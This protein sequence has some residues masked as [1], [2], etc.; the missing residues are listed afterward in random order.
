MRI[1]VDTNILLRSAQPNHPLCYKATRAV[2]KLLR[3]NAAVFFCPQNIAELCNVA[4]RPTAMNGLGFSLSEA[5][6]EIA[7]IEDL[8]TLLPD[9][10]AIYPGKQLVRGHSVRGATIYDAR[11]VAVMSV[12]EVDSIFTFN[13]V[14]FQRYGN[15]KRPPTGRGARLRRGGNL[16]WP[17]RPLGAAS[18]GPVAV[19]IPTSP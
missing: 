4:T 16:R 10:P 9:I 1:L 17:G 6:R 13:T 12:Y 2:S 19:M 15:V 14:D 3:G 7:G 5:Q 11:L 8:L 18:G